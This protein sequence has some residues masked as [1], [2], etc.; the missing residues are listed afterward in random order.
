[1]SV[2]VFLD[3]VNIPTSFIHSII[4]YTVQNSSLESVTLNFSS[5]ISQFF[6]K[7]FQIN[8]VLFCRP[9]VKRKNVY[10]IKRREFSSS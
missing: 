3:R 9:T 7:D 1:M 6:S 8:K 4:Y 5:L 2:R 10:Y